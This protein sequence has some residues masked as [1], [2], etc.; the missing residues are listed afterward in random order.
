MVVAY[1]RHQ[2]FEPIRQELVDAGF[3]NLSVTEVQGSGRQKAITQ[4]YV[5]RRSTFTYDQC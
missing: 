1:I 5:A 2:A 4:Q 3:T